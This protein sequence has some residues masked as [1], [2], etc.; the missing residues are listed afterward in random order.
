MSSVPSEIIQAELSDTFDD[1]ASVSSTDSE[2]A[3]G[4]PSLRPNE[5]GETSDNDDDND[6]ESAL[7]E[8]LAELRRLVAAK[9]A[10]AVSSSSATAKPPP[11]PLPPPETPAQQTGGGGIR[12]SLDPNKSKL[13]RRHAPSLPRPRTTTGA[14]GATEHELPRLSPWLPPKLRSDQARGNE[15]VHKVNGTLSRPPASSFV[16][17]IAAAASP[18]SPS[19]A[20]IS[21]MSDTMAILAHVDSCCTGSLTPH[22]GWLVNLRPCEESFVSAD[23][24][25]CKATHIGDMPIISRDAQGKLAKITFSNVRCVPGFKYTL[26]SVNQL[27]NEQRIDSRFADSRRLILPGKETAHHRVAARELPFLSRKALPT[28]AGVSAASPSERETAKVSRFVSSLPSAALPAELLSPLDPSTA[29]AAVGGEVAATAAAPPQQLQPAA[30]GQSTVPP[31]AGAAPAAAGPTG[32]SSSPLGTH[33]IDS[34]S[35]VAR[36]PAVQA[37]ELIHR[38]CHAGVDKIRALANTTVDGSKNLASAP[39]GTA[40]ACTTCAAARIKKASHSGTLSAPAAEPGTLHF[41]IKELVLGVGGVRY[42]VFLIDEHCRFVFVDFL[43]A[44]SDAAASVLRGRAA[45]LAKVNAGVD[46]DGRPLPRPEVRIVHSDREGGLMSHYFRA[47]RADAAIHHETSPPHDHDLNPIAERTIGLISETASAMLADSGLPVCFW[48][49]IV[50]HAVNWHNGMI[51]SV[52][53]STADA[54]ISPHQRLTLKPPRVMDLAAIGCRAVALK[55]P[56]EQ[57]KM[58]LGLRGHIGVFLGRSL[59]SDVSLSTDSKGSYD[60]LV[61]DKIVTSSSVMIDEEW[62]DLAAEGRRHR[63][64]TALAH[65]PPA[66]AAEPLPAP[67][68]ERGL[69]LLSLFSGPYARADGL[70]PHLTGLNWSSVEQFDCDGERGGGWEHDLLNDST[71]ASIL[72][73]A[74][75]GELDA[76]MV[77]FPCST[78]SVTRFFDASTDDDDRG[79]PVIRTAAFPDG[80]PK[81]QIDPRHLRELQMSNLLLQRTACVITAARKSERK[82][83][84]IFENP[85]DRS[86]RPSRALHERSHTKSSLAHHASPRRAARIKNARS[87][88]IKAADDHPIGSLMW[89]RSSSRSR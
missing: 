42:I 3:D 29:V 5:G 8:Q 17:P 45:F 22:I 67:A 31:A 61:G 59:S 84:I 16:P 43:K 66:P 76:I 86:R 26:L 35:H 49:H 18:E 32:K 30:G 78:F 39:A 83:T 87:S 80:L 10:N 68:P 73:R 88:R 48:P 19:A 9:R 41:D 77:A 12:V 71:Y 13:E 2:A 6:D 40:S 58:A 82:T 60:V 36:L 53:S 46:S 7:L 34:T 89:W 81:D 38:R 25:T 15:V 57:D 44:K 14:P 11:P 52:G 4:P 63:P 37:A 75:N 33:K 27:W 62:F 85:A 79:P 56:K 24:K 64:L 23:G 50:F 47:F 21:Q 70:K 20:F 55:A 72:A 1:S 74:I 54:N 51:S 65:A 28:I 69:R